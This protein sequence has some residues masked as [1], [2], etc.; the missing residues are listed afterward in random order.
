[1]KKAFH[2]A[3]HAN[4]CA[5]FIRKVFDPLRA[6][7][8]SI[9]ATEIGFAKEIRYKPTWT[10]S[11]LSDSNKKYQRYQMLTIILSNQIS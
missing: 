10:A 6:P 11:T 5:L 3:V 2:E 7:I 9:Q 4:P 1:M 8:R